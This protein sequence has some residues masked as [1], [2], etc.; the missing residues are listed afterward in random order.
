M[1][2]QKKM[3]FLQVFYEK[4]LCRVALSGELF[5]FQYTHGK[6]SMQNTLSI[7]EAY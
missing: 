7:N 4:F 5:K 6:T 2:L 3:V 1:T